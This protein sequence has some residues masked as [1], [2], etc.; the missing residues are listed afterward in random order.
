MSIEL[1]VQRVRCDECHEFV[2]ELWYNKELK[3]FHWF[4]NSDGDICRY[5]TPMEKTSTLWKTTKP[6]QVYSSAIEG[7]IYCLSSKKIEWD[8]HSKSDREYFIF[9]HM[10]IRKTET[11][12]SAPR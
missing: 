3:E 2:D 4:V 6:S 5:E 9:P 10:C 12:T 11:V 8:L 7:S 1:T